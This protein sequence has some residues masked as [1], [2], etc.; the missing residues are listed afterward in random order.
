MLSLDAYSST[1]LYVPVD[2]CVVL[3][4]CGIFAAGCRQR[5]TIVC[6]CDVVV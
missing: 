3:V 6:S 2:C 5:N 1:P 4:I